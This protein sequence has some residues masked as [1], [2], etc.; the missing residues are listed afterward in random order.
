MTEKQ[1]VEFEYDGAVYHLRDFSYADMEGAKAE[2]LT[3]LRAD[4]LRSVCLMREALPP[5]EWRILW[6]DALAQA[7]AIRTVTAAVL[8]A[9][10]DSLDGLAFVACRTLPP[11]AKVKLPT[12][13]AVKAAIVAKQEAGW[14]ERMAARADAVKADLESALSQKEATAP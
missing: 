3:A 13:E 4:M 1:A 11:E 10:L 5:E 9:W 12:L 8:T 6:R 2:A 7:A 14:R